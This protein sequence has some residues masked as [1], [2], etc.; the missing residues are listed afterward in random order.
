MPPLLDVFATVVD[1]RIDKP[2]AQD[3]FLV[4]TNVW[5]WLAY[6]R[7]QQG[8]SQPKFHQTKF[9][10]QY[11]KNAA[12]SK[13]ALYYCGLSFA[14]LAHQIEQKEREIFALKQGIKPEDIAA[15]LSLKEFRHNYLPEH[16]KVIQEIEGVW[17][18]IEQYGKNLELTINNTSLSNS[19]KRLT[20][21]P[22]ENRLDGYDLF[23]LEIMF[24][25]SITNIITDDGDFLTVKGITVFTANRNAID[26][27]KQAGK[28]QSR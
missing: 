17:Q 20:T 26:T 27:A 3:K 5:Y 7:S 2:K 11:I 28:L 19:L 18:Q 13:S 14:E 16:I 12:A 8:T 15:K 1:L 22:K 25:N 23:F 4:D 10:P 6:S 21:E 9:Y 24:S